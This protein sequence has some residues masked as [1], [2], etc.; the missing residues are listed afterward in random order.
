MQT[1][2]AIVENSLALSCTFEYDT[3][4][5]IQHVRFYVYFPKKLAHELSG[6][7]YNS[8]DSSIAL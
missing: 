5:I 6:D 4:L 1:D 8:D 7:T 3:W 2:T